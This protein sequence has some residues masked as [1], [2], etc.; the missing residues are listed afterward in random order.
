MLTTII[1]RVSQFT[2][3]G[4]KL[5]LLLLG[6]ELSFIKRRF[7]SYSLAVISELCMVRLVGFE[8]TTNDVEDQCSIQTELQA[9]NF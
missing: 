1:E 2:R 3:Y 7:T 6:L 4:I 5:I 9:H 8:P